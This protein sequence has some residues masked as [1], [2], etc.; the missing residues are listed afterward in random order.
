MVRYKKALA[1]FKRHKM[2]PDEKRNFRLG[3]IVSA[4]GISFAVEKFFLGYRTP[5]SDKVWCWVYGIFAAISLFWWL[6]DFIMDLWE[7]YTEEDDEFYE[8]QRKG[9]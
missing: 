6:E 9:K 2:T 7:Q 4:Y 1:Y 8:S 3:G 5:Y